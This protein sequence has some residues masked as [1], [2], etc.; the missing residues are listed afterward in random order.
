MLVHQ[1]NLMQSK[2]VC[3]GFVCFICWTVIECGSKKALGEIQGWLPRG[4]RKSQG[5][6]P[7]RRP[8]SVVCQSPLASMAAI[9]PTVVNQ[10][11]YESKLQSICLL[12]KPNSSQLSGVESMTHLSLPAACINSYQQD[13][14]KAYK[15]QHHRGEKIKMENSPETTL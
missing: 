5:N 9:V 8:C 14:L 2:W 3:W 7:Y 11:A 12:M 6:F 1:G 4:F 15:S 10:A 13:I